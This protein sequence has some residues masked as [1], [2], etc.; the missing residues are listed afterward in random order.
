MSTT[1]LG[2][3]LLMTYEKGIYSF[4][5]TSENSCSWTTEPKKLA[6]SRQRHVMLTVPSALMKSCWKYILVC[7]TD[8]KKKKVNTKLTFCNENFVNSW[9]FCACAALKKMSIKKISSP[10]K[11]SAEIIIILIFAAKLIFVED[12]MQKLIVFIIFQIRIILF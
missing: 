7:K 10:L 1:S 3:G 11:K 4:K 5:C 12:H 6:I 9:N 8:S 2:D